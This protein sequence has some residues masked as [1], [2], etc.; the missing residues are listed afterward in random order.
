MKNILKKGLIEIKNNPIKTSIAIISLLLDYFKNI[1]MDNISTIINLDYYLTKDFL[2]D[3]ILRVTYITAI[4]VYLY[5]KYKEYKNKKQE[6]RKMELESIKT[7]IK[8]N[9]ESIKTLI[10]D[11]SLRIQLLNAMLESNKLI[12]VQYNIVRNHLTPKELV[13]IGFDESYINNLEFNRDNEIGSTI[14]LGNK[15]SW[16]VKGENL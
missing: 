15:D 10:K 12:E 8:D 9:L 1:N 5:Q 3:I 4:S 6:E 2:I 14:K 11:H 7:L 16:K 13:E